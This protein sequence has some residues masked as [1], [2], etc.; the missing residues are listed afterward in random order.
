[1]ALPV[2]QASVANAVT[3]HSMTGELQM[4]NPSSPQWPVRRKTI[5][6]RGTAVPGPGTPINQKTRL[7]L[8]TGVPVNAT[9]TGVSNTSPFGATLTVPQS[10][11][12]L[13]GWPNFAYTR[14]SMSTTGMLGQLGYAPGR[15]FRTFADFTNVA[16]LT[17]YYTTFQYKAVFKPGSGAG[18]IMWCPRMTACNGYNPGATETGYIGVTPGPN[19]FGGTFRQLRQVA[20]DGRTNVWFAVNFTPFVIWKSDAA[21][22]T[23]GTFDNRAATTPPIKPYW[24]A[25][26]PNGYQL[27]TLNRQPDAYLNGSFT[28]GVAPYATVIKTLGTPIGPATYMG[29]DVDVPDGRSTGFKMTTGTIRV[30]DATPVPPTG[31]SYFYSTTSGYDHRDANGNGNIVLVGGG[32]AYEGA[33]NNKFFRNTRLKMNLPEPGTALGLGFALPVLFGLDRI[34]RKRRG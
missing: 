3:S 23:H 16:Q 25:G 17:S 27:F 5:T 6:D 20:D 1:L 28:T 4:E 19:Q 7:V 31:P 21:R 30:S 8:S 32:I 2:L 18:S 14:D 24:P 15:R 10:V 29:F 12:R 33:T 9:P 26:M 34:R 22:F 13:D 11:W